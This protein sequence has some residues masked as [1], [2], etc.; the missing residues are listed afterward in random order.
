MKYI[1]Y[2]FLIF[3]SCSNSTTTKPKDDTSFGYNDNGLLTVQNI[4]SLY[5]EDLARDWLRIEFHNNIGTDVPSTDNIDVNGTHPNL[6]KLI[7][8]STMYCRFSSDFTSG[9]A[10]YLNYTAADGL[11]G[12]LPSIVE[13]GIDNRVSSRPVLHWTTTEFDSYFSNYT[14]NFNTARSVAE[15]SIIKLAPGYYHG[16]D[17]AWITDV[18]F[19]SEY[20]ADSVVFDYVNFREK[21]THVGLIGHPA[22]G[23]NIKIRNANAFFGIGCYSTGRLRFENLEIHHAVQGIQVKTVSD[24]DEEPYNL[25]ILNYQALITKNIWIHDVDQEA[26]YIGSDVPA[27]LIPINWVAYGLVV[28]RT[29]RDVYQY[30]NGDY[31]WM[32]NCTM[33]SVGLNHE[34]PH[35]HGVLV[36]TTT[37]GAWIENVTGSNIYGYGFQL[38]GYGR[39]TIKNCNITSRMNTVFIKNYDDNDSYNMK[40]LVV[41]FICAGNVFDCTTEVEGYS[42]DVRRDDTK[43]PIAVHVNS[44]TTFVNPTYIEPD[45]GIEYKTGNYCTK[46]GTL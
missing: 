5:V 14:S 22:A 10:L 15:G 32:K 13:H 35:A 19:E 6:I 39:V 9:A 12:D 38:N 18:T 36:G 45:K 31:M 42:L 16:I 20:S 33:D 1:I 23:R 46:G 21:G 3:L 26:F 2:C 8:D 28:N 40:G 43:T 25:S 29:G 4:K 24:I 44:G 7:D 34:D 37:K 41:E 27:P 11:L 30:R 17:I